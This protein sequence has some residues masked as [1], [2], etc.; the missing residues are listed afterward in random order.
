MSEQKL[1]ARWVLPVDAPPI[2]GGVVT[3]A[4]GCIAAVDRCS[5]ADGA[6]HDLGDV[7]LMPGLVNAHTHLEFSHLEQPLGQPGMPLPEWLP[8]VIAD[9]KRSGHNPRQA[10]AAGFRESL[11]HGV[12]TI[13]EIAT[14][15]LE[16]YLSDDP[17]PAATLF[18]EV[19][20]FSAARTDSVLAAVETRLDAFPHSHAKGHAKGHLYSAAGPQRGPRPCAPQPDNPQPDIPRP[21][22]GISPH[23]PYTVHPNLLRRLVDLA[24]RHN[25]PVA[26]HLAESPEELQLLAHGTGLFQQLLDKRSMWD[27]GAIAPG[28]RPLD[29]LHQLAQAPR[30]LAVHGNYFDAEEIAFLAEHAG[31]MA[32]VYCPRTH[33]YFGH[34]PYPLGKMLAAGVQVALGTDSRASNPDLSLLEEVREAGRQ[35]PHVAAEHIIRLATLGGAKSLG[36]GE[37]AGSIT[38]GKWANLTAIAC[39]NEPVDPYEAIVL[40]E[41]APVATWLFGKR[42]ATD[43]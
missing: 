39:G 13:G 43:R 17:Q 38:P 4:N 27:A 21:T 30:T 14:A 9:R 12:T 29:Y 5:S 23:A 10:I 8:L 24:G 37:V 7:V 41:D 34:A 33:A 32:V 28:T 42:T 16:Q 15:P 26:M 22:Q 18:H 1:K 35:H 36:L 25:L 20:G 3:I 2:D 11:R 19:I 40:G 6:T 31:T